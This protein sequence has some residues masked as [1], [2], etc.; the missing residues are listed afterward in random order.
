[1]GSVDHFLKRCI[2][3]ISLLVTHCPTSRNKIET[4]SSAE[5]NDVAMASVDGSIRRDDNYIEGVL[6]SDGSTR[7]ELDEYLLMPDG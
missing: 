4:G 6:F 1:M 2:I 7:A 5:V 3:H